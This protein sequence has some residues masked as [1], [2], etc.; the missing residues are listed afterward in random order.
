MEGTI[1]IKSIEISNIRGIQNFKLEINEY[2]NKPIIF[3][4][5]NGYGKSSIACAFAGLK[6]KG[7][8]MDQE[9]YNDFIG[10][11]SYFIK[12]EIRNNGI[13]KEYLSNISQNDLYKDYNTFVIRNGLTTTNRKS[14]INGIQN[15]TS[16]I[17]ME[18]VVLKNKITKS[19][20]IRF[21]VKQLREK[22]FF[23]TKVIYDLGT[24]LKSSENI[25]NIE[26]DIENINLLIKS[27]KFS[28]I[29]AD[30][31]EIS[32]LETK[33]EL[34]EDLTNKVYYDLI[35]IEKFK[36]LYLKYVDFEQN[37]LKKTIFVLTLI[38]YVSI[39]YK[40]IKEYKK[41]SYYNK[42]VNDL[43][44][45]F[46]LLSRRGE[47][48]KIIE[49][50]KKGL[51]IEFPNPKKLSNGERDLFN[52]VANL[53]KIK[54][55]IN[56]NVRKDIILIIDEVFDYFDDLNMLIVQNMIMEFID[57]CKEKAIN[58]YPIIMTHLDPNFFYNFTF[59]D[60]KIHYL[61]N[62][63][64]GINTRLKSVI[65]DRDEYDNQCKKVYGYD[66]ISLSF[67]HYSPIFIDMNLFFSSEISEKIRNSDDFEIYIH[68]ELINYVNGY[69]VDNLAV[70][71][72]I[73]FF[74]E[75]YLY[76][77]LENSA[78]LDFIKT[79]RT[80]D[81]IEYAKNNGVEILE[82]FYFLSV[83]YNDLMHL[84]E[85][86]EGQ[87]LKYLNLKFNNIFLKNIISKFC[88]AIDIN[89]LVNKKENEYSVI[90]KIDDFL[91]SQESVVSS[92]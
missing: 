58:I 81:K 88:D 48:I 41:Y 71:C 62:K 87:K 3:V 43:K 84:D 47:L 68:K 28:N 73:R 57:A 15:V 23:F 70:A 91:K 26:S 4:A 60:M 9:E 77:N 69:S 12:M 65:L 14:F 45:Y 27:K 78:K 50:L 51:Y 25:L 38:Y 21:D 86:R 39:N 7:L 63:N 35:R 82:I 22:E 75:K 13:I 89:E 85:N 24:F 37:T 74:T 61:Y 16:S 5:P 54:I 42:Q 49:D 20:K 44:K 66:G 53:E 32:A 34:E 92:K 40:D 55:K 1:M 56:E 72:S 80:K 11:D 30:I 8:Y 31:N 64:D 6:S 19:L 2:P 17:S 10:E 90:I 33:K 59:K 83:I 18:K 46:S 79:H 67:F 76:F 29:I 52:F 36:Q